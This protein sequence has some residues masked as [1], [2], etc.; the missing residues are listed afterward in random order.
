MKEKSSEM[1]Y[2]SANWGHK[3]NHMFEIKRYNSSESISTLATDFPITLLDA[4]VFVLC[5]GGSTVIAIDNIKHTITKNDIFIV[6][7]KVKI[8]TFETSDDYSSISMTVNT[9]MVN[10]LSVG[11]SIKAYV[12]IVQDP[13]LDISE[14]EAEL[15]VTALEYIE[16][17]SKQPAGYYEPQLYSNL[18][19]AF[20]YEVANVFQKRLKVEEIKGSKKNEV[21]Q[22]FIK[23]VMDHYET[24]H[25]VD[26]YAERL[27][28]SAKYLCMVIKEVSNMPPQSWINDVIIRSAKVMLTTTDMSINEITKKL[29]F[30]N[31]S[32]FCQYFKRTV[33]KT[34]L[35]YRQCYK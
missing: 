8:Q 25:R 22:K 18:V 9:N 26:F 28:M 14:S 10:Y 21:F 31:P 2:F 17:R 13:C 23:E 34:P 29:N 15:L 11:S 1:N 4:G 32:F 30:P 6:F 24:E 20:C 33:G 27:G 5:T 35:K 19:R 16:K 12:R 3:K 7:P